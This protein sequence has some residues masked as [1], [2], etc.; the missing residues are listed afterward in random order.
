MYV[1]LF[2]KGFYKTLPYMRISWGYLFIAAY[3]A[4]KKT[5][6]NAK[7]SMLHGDAD[8]SMTNH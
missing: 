5:N 2:Y 7:F 3:S 1:W 6:L 8:F 4:P